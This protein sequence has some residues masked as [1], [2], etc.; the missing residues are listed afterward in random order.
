MTTWC[1]QLLVTVIINNFMSPSIAKVFKFCASTLTFTVTTRCCH[2]YIPSCAP[3]SFPRHSH[4]IVHCLSDQFQHPHYPPCHLVINFA[5]CTIVFHNPTCPTLRL[6]WFS[7]SASTLWSTS[8]VFPS[9]SSTLLEAKLSI[10]AG[11]PHVSAGSTDNCQL[12]YQN[13]QKE[14]CHLYFLELHTS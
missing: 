11:G 9:M 13:M 14:S 12:T 7:W 3:Y 1:L 2:S 5:A 6:T 10:T 8:S 4:D